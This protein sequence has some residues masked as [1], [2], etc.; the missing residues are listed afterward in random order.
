MRFSPLVLLTG[1]LA[2]DS[3][4]LENADIEGPWFGTVVVLDQQMPDSCRAS[5]WQL[6]LELAQS[7]GLISGDGTTTILVRN[8]VYGNTG[9][10][11]TSD[12]PTVWPV[13]GGAVTIPNFSLE[14]PDLGT[15]N[16]FVTEDE[17]RGDIADTATRS[18]YSSNAD[19]E[20]RDDERITFRRP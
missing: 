17:L 18:F 2:C 5:E 4:R 8:G 9:C 20:L 16:G 12:G 14:L 10:T 6:T 7:G 15:L 1:L 11:E 19:G 13:A 3:D